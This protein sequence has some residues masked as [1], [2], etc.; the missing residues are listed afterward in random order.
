M[1]GKLT[2]KGD[3]RA[4]S[5][6][7]PPPSA[8]SPTCRWSWSSHRS[9]DDFSPVHPRRTEI[10]PPAPVSTET[11][12]RTE[13]APLA[14]EDILSPDDEVERLENARKRLATRQIELESIIRR[15]NDAMDIVRTKLCKDL[16]LLEILKEEIEKAGSGAVREQL[17]QDF[18]DG[19]IHNVFRFPFLFGR[20]LIGKSM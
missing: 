1:T 9:S 3:M 5:P 10:H 19:T 17:E 12:L 2:K 13:E 14:V 20:K 15:A 18:H 11:S 7:T 16:Q 8:T 4:S 6:M